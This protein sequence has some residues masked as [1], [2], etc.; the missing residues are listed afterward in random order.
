MCG[1]RRDG[2]SY[3]LGRS[4]AE[5]ARPRV[6]LV[7]DNLV[8]QR[9]GCRLLEKLGYEAVTANDGQQALD[10]LVRE[11]AGGGGAARG[12]GDRH[13]SS[14]SGLSVP[15]SSQLWLG[16][17]VGVDRDGA[18][19]AHF[20]WERDARPFELRFELFAHWLPREGDARAPAPRQL[21]LRRLSASHPRLPYESWG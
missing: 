19:A 1:R 11:R 5:A 4:A 2:R 21:R 3:D 17:G 13:P 9:L 14:D 12:D 15:R 10:V 6:L 20:Y 8:N 7:E 18:F 16:V